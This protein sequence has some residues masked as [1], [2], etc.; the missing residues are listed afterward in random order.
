MRKAAWVLPPQI[1]NS[2]G[3]RTIFQNISC[4]LLHGYKCDVYVPKSGCTDTASKLQKEAEQYF[5][6]QGCRYVAGY[7]LQ[8]RYD[9]LFATS[10]KTAAVVKQYPNAAK[11][12]YFIQ[13]F[14]AA[15]YPAGT[16]YLAAC[17]SYC[18]G[19]YPITI[20][21]WLAAKMMDEY[22]IPARFFDFCTDTKIYQDLHKKREKA[23]CF[24]YQP[25]K[26]RRCSRLGL[27]AL[28]IVSALRP[29]VKIYLY[30]SDQ[31]PR[32]PFTYE[33]MGCL[34]VEQCNALYNRCMAGLCISASNPSRIPFEMMAAGLPVVDLYLENNLYDMPQEG[35][36]LAHYTPQ[37]IA[38]ALLEILDH[39]KKAKKMS[40]CGQR[41]MKERTLSHGFDQFYEA[42]AD[43]LN[44]H[45]VV[46]CKPDKIYQKSPV[47]SS[48]REESAMQKLCSRKNGRMTELAGERPWWL[49]ILL[50]SRIVR[51][52]YGRLR[53]YS[54]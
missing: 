43:I 28:A 45:A 1:E 40:V 33:S 12:V 13:D 34:C 8:G 2:G 15:F 21:R 5:G 52:V 38:A 4:L 27:Q 24:I 35:A 54:L 25:H 47:V 11:K 50:N 46:C 23:V 19:L 32:V 39:P 41:F 36:L 18:Q 9:I 31:K 42:A 17:A 3:F 51:Y 30:G 26:P 53:G 14:E 29:D 49:R 20:G 10:W 16:E 44:D 48:L 7:Q 22:H 37:S 6:V